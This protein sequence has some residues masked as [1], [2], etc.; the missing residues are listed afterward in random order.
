[1]LCV[2]PTEVSDV[3]FKKLSASFIYMDSHKTL[4]CH[5]MI[6]DIFCN[7]QLPKLSALNPLVE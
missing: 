4:T 3:I 7:V 2:R 5:H 6:L 1:M